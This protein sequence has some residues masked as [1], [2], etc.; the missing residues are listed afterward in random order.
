MMRFLR[1]LPLVMFII[2]ATTSVYAECTEEQRAR[3]IK[4]NIP[5]E[6][7]EEVCSGKRSL[8][9]SYADWRLEQPNGLGFGA[10]ISDT[11]GLMIFYDMNLAKKSQIH[12]QASTSSKSAENIFGH[13]IIKINRQLVLGTYRRFFSENKGFYYGM[14]VGLGSTQLEYEPPLSDYSYKAEG[15]G[16]FALGEI[17]WQGIR[18]FYFHIGFQ[19]ALY[20]TY[21][22]NYDENQIPTDYDH[23]SEATDGWEDSKG[24]TQ[25]SIGLGWFF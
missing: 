16:I 17:G 1:N 18:G 15:V 6:V 3:M 19:P 12:I 11:L 9:K 24:I 2:F 25:L 14:G 20:L 22:D 8:S 13:K 7:I 10:S 5:K 21:N 4:D 23:R